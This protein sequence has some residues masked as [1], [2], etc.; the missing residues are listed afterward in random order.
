MGSESFDELAR[1][2]SDRNSFRLREPERIEFMSLK[3]RYCLSVQIRV[4][5][6]LL[7]WIKIAVS[8]NTYYEVT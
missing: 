1:T 4:N 3:K 2:E 8:E 5:R 6:G 7:I